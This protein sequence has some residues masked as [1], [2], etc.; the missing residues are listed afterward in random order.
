MPWTS[1]LSSARH[2]LEKRRIL[3]NAYYYYYFI[4]IIYD[5]IKIKIFVVVVA[6]EDNNIIGGAG[7][8][9]HLDKYCVR[10]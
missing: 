3:C 10:T 4:I 9:T 6:V 1:T 8:R 5:I 7:S 2:P